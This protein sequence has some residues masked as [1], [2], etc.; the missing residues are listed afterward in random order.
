[1][2]NSDTPSASPSGLQAPGKQVS[3]PMT[4]KHIERV[5]ASFADAAADA[6]RLG[7]D[8]IEIHGAH[9]YLIDQFFWEG[10]NQRSDAFGGSMDNRGRFAAEIIRA[11]RSATGPDFPIVLRYSQW[12]QQDFEA[13][14][15]TTPQELEL[16]LQP[17]V[18]AGLDGFH[19]ST[20]RYWESEFDGSDLNLAGWTKKLTGKTAITVGSVGLSADFIGA[21]AMNESSETRAI[22]D[23]LSRLETGE[24]DLVAVGRALLQDPEWP[25]K[26]REGRTDSI[27]SFNSES[28]ATL[29]CR[30]LITRGPHLYFSW[31]R[32]YK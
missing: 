9:G 24:F 29:S 25:D 4:G 11:A 5:I 8:G 21:I 2:N 19:C 20:R 31:P 7:F 27:H 13:K 26:V 1:M 28:L 14:L 22:D 23:L 3:E 10:L 12:K 17:L 6:Q 16:F 15:A 32:S 30:F 18:D